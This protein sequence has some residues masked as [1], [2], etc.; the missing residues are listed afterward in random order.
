VKRHDVATT[1]TWMRDGTAFLLAALDRVPDDGFAAPSGLPEWTRAHVTAHVARN[2]EALGRL[3]TWAATGVETL[4]YADRAQ[5]AAEI[6]ATAKA[7]PADLRADVVRTA[8]ALDA[9]VAG[10]PDAAWRAEV[11]SA[12]GRA[13]PAADVPWMRVREVWLHALD[14]DTG[15]RV[16]D[17]PAGVVDTLLDDVTGTIASREDAP[18][19]LLVATD[20]DRTWQ[21]GAE[22]TRVSGPAAELI[23]W[24]TGRSDG[25]ALACEGEL[26]ALPR[27]L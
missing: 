27:W 12:L 2:A 18:P 15:A 8:E 10:L 24:L 14:L 9:A 6:E 11:R 22:G 3:L 26:P 17:L 4:M 20:R 21:V 5:R 13:I 23:A 25:A 7:S 16:T 19:L 1:S